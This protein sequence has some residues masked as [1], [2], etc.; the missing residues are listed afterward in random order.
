MPELPEVEVVRAGLD[1]AVTG[2]TVLGV[3]VADER[4]LTRH[5]GGGAHF[6]A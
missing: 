3:T 1:P 5:P 4:A 2:A 6:E